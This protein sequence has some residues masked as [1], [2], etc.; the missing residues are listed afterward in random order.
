M[1]MQHK[2]KQ[3][4]QF[5]IT[6]TTREAVDA[7]IQY[8]GLKSEDYLFSSRLH[9]SPHISTRQYARILHRC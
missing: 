5:E 8:A 9:D 6:A 7:W 4:V 2:T 3:P 1:V